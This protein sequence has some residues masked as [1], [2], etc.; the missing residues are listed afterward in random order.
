MNSETNKL[1]HVALSIISH[2]GKLGIW[3]NLVKYPAQEHYHYLL[4]RT[5]LAV[6]DFI[7]PA[8]GSDPLKASEKIIETS[9]KKGI[10]IQTISD[11]GYPSL[12]REIS[13]PPSVIYQKGSYNK[14]KLIAVVGTRKSDPVSESIAARISVELSSVGFGIISG[15]AVGIDRSSHIGAL[16]KEGCTVGV[17]ANGLDIIYPAQN[18]D[19]F[20]MI[21]ESECSSL[22]SEYPPSVRPGR[23]TFVRRNRIISGMAE[24]TVVVKA[25]EKSGALITAGY[26]VEQGRE[27]FVCPGNS[28]DREYKGCLN[29]I[30]NGAVPVYDTGDILSELPDT[31][32]KRVEVRNMDVTTNFP[33][34]VQ[35][36]SLSD[37]LTPVE[38]KILDSVLMG[39]QDIDDIVRKLKIEASELMEAVMA[40]EFSGRIC[41]EGNFLRVPAAYP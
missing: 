37:N 34:K 7:V 16:G 22:I 19:I 15:M 38:E 25:G 1:Y 36:A 28:F 9:K 5:K 10:H 33:E 27:V 35:A 12:L 24:G 40:L 41:R 6:Q 20:K 3:K 21:D 31:I 8:Y 2:P 13:T 39:N 32:R 23:W 30:R 4:K 26:A 29:L 18:R 14:M 17:L 11:T